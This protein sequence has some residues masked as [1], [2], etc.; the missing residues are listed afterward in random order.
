MIEQMVLLRQ[1]KAAYWTGTYG[2]DNNKD[3]SSQNEKWNIDILYHVECFLLEK[4]GLSDGY[5]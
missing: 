2:Q 4:H 1:L 3:Y 5:E